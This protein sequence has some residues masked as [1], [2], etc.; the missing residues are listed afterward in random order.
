[1]H[2]LSPSLYEIFALSLPRG[3]GF[4]RRP[5]ISFWSS[6]DQN[7]CGVVRRDEAD[8]SFGILVMRRRVDYVWAV[9]TD[10]H[11]FASAAQAISDLQ[12]HLCG[13]APGEPI[14]AGV[15][16]HQPLYE[17]AGREP[18]GL[19]KL[20]AQRTH[21]AAAWTLNQAYLALPRPDHN[22]V[23]DFQTKNFHTRMWEAMLIA[24]FREQGVLVTQP[25][26]SPDFRLENRRGGVAWVEAVTAN[27]SASYDH[28]NAE[29]SAM[30]QELEELFFGKAAVRFAK[31]LGNKIT[32]RYD[33][34]PHVQGQPFAIALADFQSGGSMIWSRQSLVG[35]LYG[36]GARE[37]LADGTRSTNPITAT[38]LKGTSRFPAGLF[39]DDR[40][41]ELSAVIFSSA[42]TLGKFNRIA[43]SRG[44]DRRGLRYTRIG[45]FF[46][47]APGA[48]RGI[49]FCMDVS[50]PEYCQLW[51]YGHEPWSAELEVFHNPFARHPMS[52]ELLREAAHWFDK[53]GDLVCESFHAPAILRSRTIIQEQSAPLLRLEDL[54]RCLDN[55]VDDEQ[56]FASQVTTNQRIAD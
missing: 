26:E 12:R 51:V 10:N 11:G 42:C 56:G 31:T 27:P 50:S 40:S 38:E 36:A 3:L 24:C 32:R 1:M 54:L 49:P 21:W 41:A 53:D 48:T 22:W 46:D 55:D 28:V 39:T 47:R 45:E 20:L 6:D 13:G 16:A 14:P 15:R 35:Y 18:S 9:T 43:I 8:G 19:F 17:V 33:Q 44:C 29:L 5:P 34:L 30:P 37:V 4:G 25:F 23:S 52:R 7:A 2:E